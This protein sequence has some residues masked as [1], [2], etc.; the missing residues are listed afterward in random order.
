LIA[1]KQTSKASIMKLLIQA[2]VAAAVLAIPAVS[3]AQPNQPSPRAQVKT[4]LV[5][6]AAAGYTPATANDYDYPPNSRLPKHASPCKM[7]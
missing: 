6:I 1:A 2:D 4:G 7:P 3:I 5:Q